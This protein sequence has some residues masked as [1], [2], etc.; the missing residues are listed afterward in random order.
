MRDYPATH[1][2]LSKTKQG[3]TKQFFMDIYIHVCVSLN[4]CTF[5]CWADMQQEKE[6]WIHLNWL[7]AL[8]AQW[9]KQRLMDH[10]AWVFQ[11][12]QLQKYSLYL[13]RIN[14]ITLWQGIFTHQEGF[15]WLRRMAKHWN[16]LPGALVQSQASEKAVPVRD[17]RRVAGWASRW[18][19]FL[20]ATAVCINT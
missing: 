4:V 12:W 1:C 15:L 13:P 3:I 2:R 8:G 9:M 11:S 10:T 5:L 19:R 7:R 6:L 20:D 16:K 14:G 17:A 18:N